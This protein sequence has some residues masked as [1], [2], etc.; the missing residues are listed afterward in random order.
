MIYNY[1]IDNHIDFEHQK[2]FPNLNGVSG[3]PLLYDFYIPSKKLLVEVNGLQHYAP[4]Q[5]FGGA[6]RFK[7]QQEHDRRKRLFA[8]KNGYRL[9][10]IEYCSSYE[11]G[12]VVKIL[13]ANL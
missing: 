10:E 6:K 11:L 1:L 8:N 13:Q 2:S 5:H 7:T 3:Y 12:N 4:V 9:L